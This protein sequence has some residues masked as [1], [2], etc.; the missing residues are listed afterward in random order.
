[1]RE[2]NFHIFILSQSQSLMRGVF[3][4]VR[5]NAYKYEWEKC[6][7]MPKV[8]N[9]IEDKRQAAGENKEIVRFNFYCCCC[10]FGNLCWYKYASIVYRQRGDEIEQFTVMLSPKESLE[11]NID[12]LSF[13]PFLFLLSILFHAI[14]I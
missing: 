8:N 12:F 2:S 7:R 4:C 9:Q 6:I 11:I 1:M 3:V 5:V 13:F 14:S 10:S